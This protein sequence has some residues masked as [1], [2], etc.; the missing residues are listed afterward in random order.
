[1]FQKKPLQAI[2][3]ALFSIMVMSGNA[4]AQDAQ[5]GEVL[6]KKRCKGC[7]RLTDAMKTGPGLLGV[8]KIRDD[9]WLNKW[10]KNPKE[11]IRSGDPVAVALKAKYKKTMRTLKAMQDEGARSDIIAFLKK[12]DAENGK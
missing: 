2:A 8:T 5:R 3:V 1:M 4:Y 7:H 9:E 11:M 10:L 6:F 12:N